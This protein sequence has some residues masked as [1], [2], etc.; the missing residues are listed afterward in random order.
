MPA[1]PPLPLS[2]PSEVVANRPDIR[3]AERRY[4]AAT[5]RIG[6]AVADLYPHFSIPL[7]LTPTNLHDAFSGASLLWMA[8]VSASTNVYQGG[9]RTALVDEAKAA[10]EIERVAY[11]QTVLTAFREVE[12][13]LASTQAEAQRRESLQAGRGRQRGR[14]RIAPSACSPRD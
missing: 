1:P 4:C 13:A 3:R 10:A 9:R 6:V 2:L 5:A 8:G 11:R 14:P 7:T 12:D